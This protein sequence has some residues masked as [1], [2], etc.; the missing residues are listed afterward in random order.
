MSK[1]LIRLVKEF[2]QDNK[3]WVISHRTAISENH[4]T[5]KSDNIM[6]IWLWMYERKEGF[7]VFNTNIS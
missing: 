5:R 7:H 4:N 2:V 1:N 6:Y 3:L